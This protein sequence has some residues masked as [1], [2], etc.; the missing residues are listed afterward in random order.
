MLCLPGCC[1]AW[2]RSCTLQTL[3]P[4]LPHLA[5]VRIIAE[6]GRYFAETI[7]TMG[8]MVYGRRVRVEPGA[9]AG[10][11]MPAVSADEAGMKL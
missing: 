1:A 9:L 7:A 10:A 4:L 6:P 3:N 8:C 11:E 5:G 2:S